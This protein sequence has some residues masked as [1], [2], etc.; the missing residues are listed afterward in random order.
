MWR[1]FFELW[2]KAVLVSSSSKDEYYTKLFRASV[3]KFV[4]QVI[5]LNLNS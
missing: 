5:G 2:V 3:G 4:D 1:Y